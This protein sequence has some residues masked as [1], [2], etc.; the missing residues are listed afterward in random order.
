MTTQQQTLETNGYLT[1]LTIGSESDGLS[2]QCRHSSHHFKNGVYQIG[3]DR[4]K[5]SL[6]ALEFECRPRSTLSEKFRALMLAKLVRSNQHPP[7]VKFENESTL[8]IVYQH[9]GGDWSMDHPTE[10][11]ADHAFYRGL[12]FADGYATAQ[13][14]AIRAPI[15]LEGTWG[16]DRTPLT[17]KREDLPLW[18]PIETRDLLQSIIEEF[19][20]AGDIHADDYYATK[21]TPAPQAEAVRH[22]I[23][24]ARIN[25][26]N[27][28]KADIERA[29]ATNDPAQLAAAERRFYAYLM[30]PPQA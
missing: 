20:A 13:L 22:T 25:R 28:F 29:R 3:M 21:S 15:A 17:V 27:R 11:T 24:D 2:I 7:L 30:A 1:L 5:H 19:T 6:I 14:R 8:L 4:V 9:D 12:K 10:P 18:K 16:D 23:D 26:V